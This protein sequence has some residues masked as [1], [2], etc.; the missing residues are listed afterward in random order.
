MCSLFIGGLD[1]R[2]SYTTSMLLSSVATVG[3]L[4]SLRYFWRFRVAQGR[5]T[6]ILAGV[7]VHCLVNTVRPD[8]HAS[9]PMPVVE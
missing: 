9:Y 8:A 7:A 5:V 1:H 6:S 2:R 4:S 3:V